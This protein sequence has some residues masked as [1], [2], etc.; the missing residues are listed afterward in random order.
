MLFKQLYKQR[1]S[2]LLGILLLLLYLASLESGRKPLPGLT[3]PESKEAFPIFYLDNVTARQFS[4]QGTLSYQLQAPRIEYRPR[5]KQQPNFDVTNLS[6]PEFLYFD[7]PQ[8]WRASAQKGVLALDGRVLVLENDVV[9]S[10]DGHNLQIK[11]DF[12]VLRPDV[13]IAMTR[14]KVEIFSKEGHTTAVGLRANL[15][16]G[17]INLLSQV[18]GTYESQ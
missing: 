10:S 8:P 3:S 5:S 4:S 1:I 14:K 12:L 16:V 7:S 6:K 15:D 13:N 11:T 9:L 2:V 17:L 18:R